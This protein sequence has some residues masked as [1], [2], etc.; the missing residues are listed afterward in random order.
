MKEFNQISL[1]D[2]ENETVQ[3]EE[4]VTKE[5]EIKSGIEK[6]NPFTSITKEFINKTLCIKENYQMPDKLLKLILS[7]EKE[8][9][10]EQFLQVDGDLSHDFFREYFQ[11]TQA[12]RSDLKQDY[13]PSCIC[14]IIAELQPNGT[15]VLDVCAGVGSLTIGIL[16]K[17]KDNYY[18]CEELSKASIPVLLFNLAI[19]NVNATIVNCNVLTREKEN[20]YKLSKGEKFSNIEQINETKQIKYDVII[21]NPPYS[22]SWEAKSDERFSSYPLAP[23]S[24]ADYAFVLDIVSRLEENGTAFIILPHGVLFRGASEGAIR[25]QLIDNNLIDTIIGL[26]DKLFLNTCIPVLIMIIKKNKTNNKILFIDSSKNF[27]KQGAQNDMSAEQIENI[28]NAYRTRKD[29][30]KFCHVATL[31]EIRKNDYNLN[32][33]RYVDTFDHE[34]KDKR[35][36]SEILK[37]IIDLDKECKENISKLSMMVQNLDGR[38]KEASEQVKEI[39]KKY[40]ELE[41]CKS[42]DANKELGISIDKLQGYV[43][44]ASTTTRELQNFAI[45]ERAIKGKKYKKGCSIIQISATKGQFMYLNEDTEI[46]TRYAVIIPNPDVNSKYLYWSAL[47]NLESYLRKV[48]QTI[49]ISFDDVAKIP[50]VWHGDK[51]VQNAIVTLFDTLESYKNNVIEAKE[52]TIS[53]KDYFLRSMFI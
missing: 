4:E 27:I 24:K 23:K 29:I 31:E 3:K 6:S 33:P 17:Q 2:L 15:K 35:T 41:K 19:R 34:I 42:E 44:S 40:K 7:E 25:K 13:T 32:I 46:E 52:S 39:Q 14:D 11:E 16:N 26:P 18:Q 10:F 51:D 37:E 8:S 49:N 38:N 50:V 22:I 30:D 5:I 20:I 12:N 45:I 43:S 28:I 9:I 21:S 53:E 36:C 48:Q 47:S 1:F